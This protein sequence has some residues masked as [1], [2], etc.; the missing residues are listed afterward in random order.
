MPK[1]RT[2]SELAK[3]KEFE[4]LQA[5]WYNK[6]RKSGFVDIECGTDLNRV[7]GQTFRQAGQNSHV[8]WD[9]ERAEHDG[10][11]IIDTSE[12]VWDTDKSAYFDRLAAFAHGL[13]N[14][15]SLW[16]KLIL[17]LVDG[18]GDSRKTVARRHKTTMTKATTIWEATVQALGLPK[19][20][21]G[22]P[23]DAPEQPAPV[24]ILTAAEK[25]RLG[26][27]PPKKWTKE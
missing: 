10:D 6:L 24:R 23:R 17:D 1:R 9:F 15:D 2:K 19:R 13:P 20:G 18:S 12:S 5:K 22:E 11:D 8:L 3:A 21:P 27:V 7:P 16:A 26:Y 4:K 25:A 14:Q